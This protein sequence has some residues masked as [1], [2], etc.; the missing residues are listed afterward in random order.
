MSAMHRSFGT[1]LDG[2]F[3]MTLAL[4]YYSLEPLFMEEESAG[5]GRF[6]RNVACKVINTAVEWEEAYLVRDA[7]PPL[8]LSSPGNCDKGTD[9]PRGTAFLALT[10]PRVLISPDQSLA[11]LDKLHIRKA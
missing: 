6:I 3:R 2:C 1:L 4:G 7:F 8:L 11:L 10:N 5:M 9:H